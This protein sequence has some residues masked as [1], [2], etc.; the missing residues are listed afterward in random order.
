MRRTADHPTLRDPPP[1]GVYT[2]PNLL[3]FYR[4]QKLDAPFGNQ[5]DNGDYFDHRMDYLRV[6]PEGDVFIKI[7]R[8]E[9][10]PN[11]GGQDGSGN[12]QWGWSDMSL[13]GKLIQCREQDDVM[14]LVVE[15]CGKF[16][17]RRDAQPTTPTPP[18][19]PRNLK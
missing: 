16:Y 6:Y 19:T 8:P 3:W 1:P 14:E 12:I 7:W 5:F 18:T 13:A 15:D 10:D 2:K 4:G 11:V 9:D 17:M